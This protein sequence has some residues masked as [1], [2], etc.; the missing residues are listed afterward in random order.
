MTC[1]I[2]GDFVVLAHLN[3]RPPAPLRHFAL[4]ERAI[5]QVVEHPP[6][7]VWIVR[8]ILHGRCICS[9][10]Y[11]PFQPVAHNWPFD[12]PIYKRT[13]AVYLEKVASLCGDGGFP[14]KKYVTMIVYASCPLQ[15]I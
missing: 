11:F 13:F 14:L 7:N 2:H 1:D 4:S 3:T 6:V 15:L 8:L 12:G 10:G 5:A 9:L